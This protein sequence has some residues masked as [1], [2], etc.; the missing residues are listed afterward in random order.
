DKLRRTIDAIDGE[1]LKLLNQRAD[2]AI[3]IGKEKSKRQ[4]PYHVPERE[5]EIYERLERLNEGPFPTESLRAVFREILSATLSLEE[6]LTVAYLGPRAT[7]T[8][9]ACLQQFGLSTR[10]QPFNSIQEVFEE[11][12]RDRVQY[13]V[14][15]IENSIEGVVNH[16]LDMFVDSSLLI[17]GEV[18]L[19]IS[20]N[21]LAQTDDLAAVTK[22]YSH[23][24]AIAQCRGWLENHLPSIPVYEVSSTAKAAEM[25]LDEPTAAA[26]ASEAAAHIYGLKIVKKRIEDNLDNVT[27]FLVIGKTP[28][29]RSGDDKTSVLFS[30]KDRVGALYAM[31]EPFASHGINL[32]KIESRPSRT[33]VWEYLFFVDLEGHVEDATVD[34]ALNQLAER[35]MFL[36]VL[37]SYPRSVPP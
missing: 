31:L 37:G 22:I 5:R 21:L 17:C 26:I 6:P 12:E 27:R 7:F 29:K 33:K 20:H 8:H 19:E 15:P 2:L 25:V 9:Q 36:K 3:A 34:E 1:I 16:T 14:I 35:C 23:P 32:T 30:I 11:V 24:H 18:S 10:Y 28:A 13:G 4:A